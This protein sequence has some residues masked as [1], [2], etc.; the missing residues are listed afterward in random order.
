MHV[1][2]RE[3]LARL[4]ATGERY[5]LFHRG[6]GTS[7][8]RGYVPG[9]VLQV[10]SI[11]SASYPNSTSVFI[12]VL[13]AVNHSHG[14]VMSNFVLRNMVE[15]VGIEM[16]FPMYSPLIKSIHLVKK[17]NRSRRAKWYYLREKGMKAIAVRG[18]L[19]SRAI[20]EAEAAKARGVLPK[21]ATKSKRSRK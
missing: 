15:G 5:S 13:I 4:D 20:Q 12:G 6:N 2:R 9:D 18:D 8:N 1:I 17:T 19:R 14:G 11:N 3:Q 16:K 10:E 7:A 21:Q